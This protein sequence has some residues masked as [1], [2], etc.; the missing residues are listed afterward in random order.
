MFTPQRKAYPAISLTPRTE[1]ARSGGGGGKGKAVA[2]LDGPPP[3]PPPPVASLDGNVMGNV[4]LEDMEDWRRFREVGLLDEA[5]MGRKDRQAIAEKVTKLEKELFDYQYNMGLLLIEKKEWNLKFEELG[6]ALSE[7]QQLLKREQSAHLIAMSEAEKK[8]ENL[9][10]ALA[11]ERQCVADLEKALHEI[12]NEQDRMKLDSEKKLAQAN[13]LTNG[14]EDRSLEVKEKLHDVDAK[15]AEV[16]RK[17]SQLD[18]KMQEMEARESVLQRERL[19][20]KTEQEAHKASFYKQREDLREWDQK[21]Q[22][23]EKKLCEDRRILNEKEEKANEID[24]LLVQKERNIEEAYTNMESSKSMLSEKEKHINQS[25]V[26]LAAKEKEVLSKESIIRSKEEKLYALENKLNLRESV[27]IQKVVDEQKALLDGKMLSF[28]TE[29]EERRKSL[30]K[31]LKIKREEI[32]RKE[33]EINHKEQKLGKRESALDAKTDRFK[34]KDKELESMLKILKEKEKSMKAEEK[35]LEVE[36][37]QLSA[38]KEA[39]KNLKDEIEKIKADIAEKKLEINEES[40]NLRLNDEERS[41][42]LRLQAELKMEIEKCRSQQ[43]SLLRESEELKEER[44]KF[45]KEWEALDEKRAA[46]IEEQRKFLEQKEKSGNWQSSE[47]ERLKRER[48]E[49]EEYMQRESEAIK[50]EKESFAAKMKHEESDLSEKVQNERNQMLR[51]FELMKVDLETSLQKRQE[52]TEKK[53]V[54]WEKQ[55]ELEK[56][57]EL[58]SINE[59]KESALR[60]LDEIRS[61]KHRI[62]KDKQALVMNKKQLDENQIKVR[63]DIDQLFLLSQKLKDQRE[64]LIKE[65]SRFL[66]FVEKFKSCE[67]CG[68]EAREFTLSDLRL[69]Q[70]G[71]K[72]I[73][74]LPR[75]VEELSEKPCSRTSP[76]VEKSPDEPG[77][78]HSDSKSRMSWLRKC[79][80]KIFNLSPIKKIEDD[81]ASP[82]SHKNFILEE[83][84]GR[85]SMAGNEETNKGHGIIEDEAELSSGK[86]EVAT[87]NQKFKSVDVIKEVDDGRAPSSLDDSSYLHDQM[88]DLP[89]G[90]QHSE[91]KKSQRKGGKRNNGIHRTRS[92]K[93]VVEDAKAFLGD[94]SKDTLLNETSKADQADLVHKGKAVSN[95][96]RKRQHAESSQITESEQD[97]GESEGPSNSVTAGGR[98]KRR[99]TVHVSAVQTPGQKRYNLR[100]QKTAGNVAA[101][102]ASVDLNQDGKVEAASG[103]GEVAINGEDNDVPSQNSDEHHNQMHLTQVTSLR[104]V[105]LSQQKVVRFTTVNVVDDIVNLAKPDGNEETVGMEELS[106]E[107]ENGSALNEADDDYDDELEHPGAASVGKKIWTFFTT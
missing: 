22:E 100:R 8:E 99:Q 44:E 75:L 59:L 2:F 37:K 67:K 48:H 102:E 19:S 86:V 6:Q 53:A 55:F 58:K 97:E 87:S 23:R 57:K 56:E 106:G 85:L 73:L 28:E 3:P 98:K 52:E 33:V 26:D 54:L 71:D 104:T 76:F 72:E 66:S 27:E 1:A 77:L 101:E 10:K 81:S 14:I 90:S 93:A 43:D 65:R 11:L 32:E 105:E 89:E 38:E 80:S 9:G 62:E 78:V 40:E 18:L 82:E 16:S 15:L 96:T 31:E 63:E 92:V 20:L 74:P 47:Q 95:V 61:E 42:H 13:A 103:G 29:L 41:E 49:M 83:N 24:Q 79:T 21:L 39:L 69:P 45:E 17:S 5:E 12:H 25:L 7:A 35:K 4:G 107:D 34:E 64:D 84:H 91:V 51:E 88:L 94:G 50:L 30:D 46:V 68:D 36:K 70:I 60:E